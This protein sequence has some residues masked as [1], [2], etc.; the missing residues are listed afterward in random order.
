[1]YTLTH[2]YTYTRTPIHTYTSA[3]WRHVDFVVGGGVP[4]SDKHDWQLCVCN[5][6]I[7]YLNNT[8]IHTHTYRKI[9][10]STAT[11]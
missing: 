5:A 11:Y 10:M 4:G 1:M 9:Y 8:H 7:A 2:T 3:V 6:Q